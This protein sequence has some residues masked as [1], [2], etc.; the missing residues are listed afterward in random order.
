MSPAHPSPTLVAMPEGAG[1]S[2]TF[3]F[4]EAPAPRAQAPTVPLVP[5][6]RL[7]DYRL[8]E[9]LGRGASASVWRA[10]DLRLHMPVA[11]KIFAP[12]GRAGRALLDG[13]MREARAASRVVSDFVI[14]V[15]DAGTFDDEALVFIAMELCAAF[16]DPGEVPEDQADGLQVGRTLEQGLPDTDVDAVRLL[17]EVAR[18]VAAA[19]RE[20]IFH[21]DIKPANI[22]VRP[23]SRRAQVTDFGLTVAELGG[24]GSVRVEL[25]GDAPRIILGTP[26]YM[27]PEA[28][29]GLPA[30]LDPERDRLLLTGLDVY[31]IGATLYAMFAGRPPYKP[32]LGADSAAL[33]LLEQVREGP[34][35]DLDQRDR[36]HL[37]AS[38]SVARVIARAMAR[39]PDHRY[40]SALALAEDLEAILAERPTSLDHDRPVWRGR[41]WLRRNRLQVSAAASVA[42]LIAALGTSAVVGQRLRA[43][44]DAGE[45]RIAD[46]DAKFAAAAA[47]ADQWQE[48]AGDAEQRFQ[49]ALTREE[50]ALATAASTA[51]NLDATRATARR[52]AAAVEAAEADAARWQE[53]AEARATDLSESRAT[54]ATQQERAEIAETERDAALASA[55]SQ[56][57]RAE[58]AE[59][60]LIAAR[61]TASE[62]ERALAAEVSRRSAAE[63]KAADL[64][65]TL[66][67]AEAARDRWSAE[68]A[69]LERALDQARERIRALEDQIAAVQGLP[70]P[71]TAP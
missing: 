32:R 52:L 24:E 53:T 45:T 65:S 49:A 57:A 5:G 13:I 62:L 18:G 12:R 19:H 14:R 38:P 34:P 10:T 31:G 47:E 20:G 35:L 23:G 28:A 17:A 3:P 26:E 16:P 58:A 22:L 56:Q 40:C 66:R 39:N 70:P 69:H 44:I 25:V 71:G 50:R 42:V 37:P 55:S 27:A 11:L 4:G 46:L 59:A 15:K 21:R 54:T 51:S 6:R 29:A 33:D 36:C 60:S 43:E 9:L 41:L 67:Q 30:Q 64:V 2:P 8:E 68:V 61:S 63:S 1:A 48:Q 7:G